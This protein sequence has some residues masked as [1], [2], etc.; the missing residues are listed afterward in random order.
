MALR[1]SG[2]PVGRISLSRVVLPLHTPYPWGHITQATENSMNNEASITL[3]GLW[4]G[5][6]A[7][8]HS[9][10]P[11]AAAGAMVGGLFFWSLSPN[12]PRWNRFWLTIASIGMGYGVGLPATRSENWMGWEWF[13][14]GAGASLSHVMLVAVMAM[15]NKNAP[16]PPWLESFLGMVLRVKNRGQE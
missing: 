4:M 8:L 14:A 12:I 11:E 2:L 13:F 6:V 1:L 16:M 10:N 9:L 3:Y 15:V 7:W 5:V